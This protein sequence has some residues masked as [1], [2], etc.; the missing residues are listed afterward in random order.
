MDSTTD[1]TE[2]KQHGLHFAAFI[3]LFEWIHMALNMG[4]SKLMRSHNPPCQDIAKSQNQHV[5]G[6][7]LNILQA[8]DMD[9]FWRSLHNQERKYW[10]T[11]EEKGLIGIPI[12][13]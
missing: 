4:S 11:G 7:D 1:P 9:M 13:V 3:S 5:T 6:G 10:T 8:K 12:L 2:D